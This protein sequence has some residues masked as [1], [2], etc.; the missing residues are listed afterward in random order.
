MKQTDRIAIVTDTAAGLPADLI[1]RYHINLVPF[2]VEVGGHSYL[3]GV[4]LTPDD[5]FNLLRRHPP[6]TLSTSVPSIEAFARLYRKLAGKAEAI[7]SIH[8]TE[9]NSATCNV[10]RLAAETAPVPVH[11][12]NT[13]TTAMGEG[14]VV[15][16]A[17]RSIARG[18]PL[19]EVIARARRVAEEAG[20]LA[21]LS[22]IAYAVRGGRVASAARLL[23][24][25]L[26]IHALVAIE[27]D[28]LV[29][30]GQARSRK[31]ALKR[32]VEKV[33]KRWGDRPVRLAVHYA[34]DRAESENLLERLKAVLN[35]VESHLLRVPPPLGVHA[36][37]D[38]IGI[39]YA[40]VLPD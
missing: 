18:L 8:L 25:L 13:R 19:D 23:G 32:V 37:P 22:D 2:W 24:S 7:L 14:F 27:D 28:R 16:E 35:C 15:L 39:A 4:D 5:F 11:V 10:A 30:A 26:R 36:G 31:A 29:I 38:A 40:P 33:Q 34:T 12:I 1:E 17:A 3:D 6:G 9:Q 21:L 20:A